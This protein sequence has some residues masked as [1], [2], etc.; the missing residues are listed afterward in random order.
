VLREPAT[1]AFGLALRWHREE[2]GWSQEAL[3]HRAGLHPTYVGQIERGEKSSTIPTIFK[4]SAGLDVTTPQLFA[5][6]ER[7]LG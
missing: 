1:V 5:A 7:F 2:R 4:L 6:T 3:A